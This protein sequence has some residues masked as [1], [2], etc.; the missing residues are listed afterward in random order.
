MI[1]KEQVGMYYF[2]H[3]MD[4]SALRRVKRITPR[5]TNDKLFYVEKTLSK[6]QESALAA[7]VNLEYLNFHRIPG[8]FH[9]YQ[10]EVYAKVNKLFNRQDFGRKLRKYALCFDVE[11]KHLQVALKRVIGK[12]IGN[13]YK[14]IFLGE[15]LYPGMRKIFL[16]REKALINIFRDRLELIQIGNRFEELTNL[17]VLFG[18]IVVRISTIK[19]RANIS[20]PMRKSIVFEQS[21]SHRY[22][23]N[24][25]FEAFY[26]YFKNRDDVVYIAKDKGELFESLKKEGK[27]VSCFRMSI[28]GIGNKMDALVASGKLA[29][30]F[31]KGNESLTL[32]MHI[33]KLKYKELYYKSLFAMYGATYYVKNRGDVDD[34]HP[35]ATGMIEK[36]KG[37]NVG[38]QHGS[39]AG[40]Y[41]MFAWID[42]H[43]YGIL[44]EY[45][46]TLVFHEVW[47]KAIPRFSIVG[48]FTC[49]TFG[50]EKENMRL[51]TGNRKSIGLFTTSIVEDEYLSRKFFEDFYRCCYSSLSKMPVEIILKEKD[52]YIDMELKERDLREK[53]G[54]RVKKVY[55]R[56]KGRNVNIA[57]ARSVIECTDAVVIMSTSSVAWE[58]LSLKQK[59]IIFEVDCI[60]HPFESILPYLVVRNERE[61]TERI[62]WL[63]SMP[64]E[65]YEKMIGP[66]IE[67]WCKPYNDHLIEDFW[68]DVEGKHA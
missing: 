19:L 59:L 33:L 40:F 21:Q 32:K 65:E 1:K 29:V 34:T 4:A 6:R 23:G 61:L 15:H 2:V 30:R 31:V 16:V 26:E 66:L 51:V 44:G 43:I 62:G 37:T 52:Y 63:L 42:F 38:F 53:Y 27:N 36:T 57:S 5:G 10:E 64:Q 17:F 55:G 39:Y 50:T 25:E 35:I 47:E 48:A 28:E 20:A 60:E 9:A 54:V 7:I 14:I 11:W 13:D 24:T 67:A 46:K 12:L 45:F 3:T 22:A 8:K 56:R 58:A 68:N 49:V 41:Y 18:K